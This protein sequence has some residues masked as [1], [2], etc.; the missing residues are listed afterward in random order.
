MA[1][2]VKGCCRLT[3]SKRVAQF[4]DVFGQQVQ[5]SFRQIDGEEEATS[6]NEV[7]TVT[8]HAGVLAWW[9]DGF[10]EGLNPSYDL[11]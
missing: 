10:R 8:G 11:W 6:G 9:D 7:A 1:S 5:P 2:I 3:F 4:V